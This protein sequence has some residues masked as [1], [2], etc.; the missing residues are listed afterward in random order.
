MRTGTG[1]IVP[2]LLA[3]LAAPGRSQIQVEMTRPTTDALLVGDAT[4]ITLDIRTPAKVSLP[5]SPKT[6]LTTAILDSGL[7]ILE[8]HE[9]VR[10]VEKDMVHHVVS[11]TVSAYTTGTF[12]IPSFGIEYRTDGKDGKVETAAMP[13]E[14]KSLLVPGTPLDIRGP[15]RPEIFQPSLPWGIA[16]G[17]TGGLALLLM[18]A[19][20]LMRK[21]EPVVVIPPPLPPYD[22]AMKRLREL[23]LENLPAGGQVK[24]HC[25]RLSDIVR[26]YLARLDLA[27]MD[28]TTD[29]LMSDIRQKPMPLGSADQ[30]AKL[31][32]T[33][34]QA[35]FARFEPGGRMLD[36]LESSTR[37]FLDLMRPSE[38]VGEEEAHGAR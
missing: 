10:P 27:T 25:D 7:E 6:L 15:G 4:T 38:K 1:W 28:Q 32:S 13:L 5:S 18:I 31:L 29:E 11:A 26:W 9:E 19:W 30:L 3:M 20:R 34:D 12:V 24:E 33:C 2:L 8:Q 17:V 36:E 14:V 37:S 22:E 16:G 21:K 23:S 35:K